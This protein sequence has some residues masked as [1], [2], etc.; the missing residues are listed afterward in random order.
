VRGSEAS[1][2]KAEELTNG[3]R[4]PGRRRPRHDL[5]LRSSS[6][7]NAGQV[8]TRTYRA[9]E[10]GTRFAIRDLLPVGSQKGSGVREGRPIFQGISHVDRRLARTAKQFP[11]VPSSSTT[12]ERVRPLGPRRQ[13]NERSRRITAVCRRNSMNNGSGEVYCAAV[14]GR[15]HR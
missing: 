15:T 6:P 4:V 2:W 5:I 3:E 1:G 14:L 9:G 10:C 8:C 12:L 13:K 7:G 11:A